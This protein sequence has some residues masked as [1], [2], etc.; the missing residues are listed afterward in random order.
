M[1]GVSIS[2]WKDSNGQG[3]L[4]VNDGKGISMIEIPPEIVW[5]CGAE[6]DWKTC[7]HHPN[8]ELLKRLG[9]EGGHRKLVDRASR[10]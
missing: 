7:G 3:L 6:I 8:S 5:A 1:E 9:M 10:A 4:I 2:I